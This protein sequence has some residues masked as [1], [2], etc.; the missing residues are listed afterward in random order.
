ME[1]VSI[2]QSN[3]GFTLVEICV[4]LLLISV[5]AAITTL[6]LI[7]WQEYSI[8]RK[9]EDNAELIYMALK[10]K[11]AQLKSDNTLKELK[12]WGSKSSNIAS[13]TYTNKY[14]T[15]DGALKNDTI[16]YF[17]CDK[18]DYENYKKN[19][20]T[21]DAN[22]KL[23]FELL[24]EYLHDKQLLKAYIAIE[25][26][27]DGIIYAVYYSDRTKFGYGAGYELNLSQKSG[28]TEDKLYEK[29]VGVYSSQ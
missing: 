14:H 10:N 22:K 1:K 9:Q 26:S 28:L 25:Y 15:V 18:T 13:F 19:P 5:L 11:I 24:S 29:V 4:V 8:N 27:D 12:N 2:R 23:M 17:L 7:S 6:S 3:K 20:A 21:Y 16:Y